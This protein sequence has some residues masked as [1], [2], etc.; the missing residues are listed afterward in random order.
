MFWKRLELKID[1]FIMK[2]VALSVFLVKNT[3]GGLLAATV[4]VK[5]AGVITGE[6]PMWGPVNWLGAGAGIIF[7][8]G[9]YITA[10][11]VG[12]SWFGDIFFRIDGLIDARRTHLVRWEHNNKTAIALYHDFLQ[13]LH[14]FV[15]KVETGKLEYRTGSVPYFYVPNTMTFSD[16]PIGKVTGSLKDL[17]ILAKDCIVEW[18]PFLVPETSG[19][20]RD[21]PIL[22]L[23]EARKHIEK[24][25]K[26]F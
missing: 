2:F 7:A 4:F 3:A 24:E 1:A 14:E 5:L 9:F 15:A 20:T 23:K 16:R 12:R 10:C 25:W 8:L 26:R 18:R 6:F 17:E 11:I 22:S 19:A 13:G 21:M